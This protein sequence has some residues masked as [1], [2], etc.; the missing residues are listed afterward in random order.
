MASER[1]ET[2][3]SHESSEL[4][5]GSSACTAKGLQAARGLGVLLAAL[6]DDGILQDGSLA[7]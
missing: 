6:C 4:A 5:A 3:C 2:D 1:A 7:R